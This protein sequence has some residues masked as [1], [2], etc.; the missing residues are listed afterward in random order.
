MKTQTLKQYLSNRH[1]GKFAQK[2]G[3]GQDTLSEIKTGKRLPGLK[4]ATRIHIETGGSVNILSHCATRVD[5][6]WVLNDPR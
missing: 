1:A 6:K 3:I 5:G 4:V 2:I